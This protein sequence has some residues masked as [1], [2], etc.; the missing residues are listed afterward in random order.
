MNTNWPMS[1]PAPE[2]LRWMTDERL[3]AMVPADRTRTIRTAREGA[4]R[5]SEAD[6]FPSA[7]P[8]AAQNARKGQS[9]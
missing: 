1:P 8:Y 5:I 4:G 6:P 2:E 7:L 3:W 9:T